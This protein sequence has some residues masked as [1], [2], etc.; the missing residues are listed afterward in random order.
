MAIRS[1]AVDALRVVGIIAI[2]AGHVWDTEM[3]RISVYTWHVP[4]FFFLTGYLWTDRRAIGIE[5]KKRTTTLLVPYVVW[6]AVIGAL[7]SVRPIL[8]GEF[9]WTPAVEMLLGGSYIGRPFSAFWFVTALFAATVLLRL[10]QSLPL[11]VPWLLACGGL[12]FS[13]AFPEEIAAVPL[14]FGVALPALV[15]VLAGAALKTVR[16]RIK[17]ELTAG[18]GLLLVCI[19]GLL[20]FTRVA[21]PMDMKQGDFGTPILS[22]LMATALSAGL[23]LVF[24][25]AFAHMGALVSASATALSLGGFMVVLTHAVPLWLLKVGNEGSVT[26]FVVALCFPWIAALVTLRTPL[27]PYLCGAERLGRSSAP[28]RQ[29]SPPTDAPSAVTGP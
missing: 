13:Y 16:N 10:L 21:S 6:L 29:A 9:D 14:A 22:V 3:V 28:K 26:G 12:A 2:V 1:G 27:A 18:L 20:A 25:V 8:Q 11:W 7:T 4:L 24:E 17:A 23:L 5:V 19:G 15:F